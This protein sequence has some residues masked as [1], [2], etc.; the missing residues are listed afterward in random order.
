MSNIPVEIIKLLTVTLTREKQDILNPE[1]VTYAAAT[2]YSIKT[3]LKKHIPNKQ[4]A[5]EILRDDIQNKFIFVTRDGQPS[6]SLDFGKRFKYTT[7]TRYIPEKIKTKTHQGIREIQ[8]TPEELRLAFSQDYSEQYINDVVTTAAVEITRYRKLTATIVSMRGKIPHFKEGTMILSGM[9][10]GI[11]EKT[12][13]LL[14]LS[15]ESLS[16]PFDKRSRN[17]EIQ[18]L[19]EIAE[20]DKK[21]DRVRLT[22]NKEGFLNVDIRLPRK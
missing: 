1:L 2:N 3:I 17:R 5:Y 10:V 19:Q 13:N 9:L 11:G 18:I 8:R 15:G 20:G 12:V 14:T 6:D 21:F 4:K 7:I 22:W 16:I